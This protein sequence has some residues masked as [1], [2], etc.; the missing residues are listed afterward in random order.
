MKR[1]LAIDFETANASRSS[2]CSIGY[3]LIEN[4]EIIKNEEVLIN[5]EEYF[6]PFN[7]SIHGITEEMGNQLFLRRGKNT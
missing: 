4:G 3:A 2:A 1:I 7:I 5:P 6:D